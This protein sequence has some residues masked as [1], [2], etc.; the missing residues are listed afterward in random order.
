MVSTASPPAC[1]SPCMDDHLDAGVGQ[2]QFPQ[3]PG[4]GDA[5]VQFPDVI[6]RVVTRRQDRD[7][8][9]SGSRLRQLR[10]DLVERDADVGRHL[11]Q[12]LG[13]DRAIG[14]QGRR[15][16]GKQLLIALRRHFA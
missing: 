5:V 7:P 8:S 1:S 9:L 16:S 13:T 12:R 2:R 11:V 3:P 10:Q 15:H 4:G 14:L 6:D